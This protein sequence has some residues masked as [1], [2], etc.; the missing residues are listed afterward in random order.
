MAKVSKR[1]YRK[2]SESSHM[3]AL[4]NGQ[5]TNVEMMKPQSSSRAGWHTHLYEMD[6]MTCETGPAFCGVD[7]A[8][9]CDL[10][11]TSGPM[12]VKNDDVPA[13]SA[14]TPNANEFG[15]IA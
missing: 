2:D 12:I 5:K 8:H 13:Q 14:N 9:D 1:V 6:G 11:M 4:P 7:H 15:T 10:G 3:H